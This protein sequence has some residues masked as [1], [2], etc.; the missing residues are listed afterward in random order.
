MTCNTTPAVTFNYAAWV[1]AYPQ[2][3]NV[4]EAQATF[5]FQIA[6][7]YCANCLRIV[8]CVDQ[9]QA[10][11]WMLTAHIAW[12]QCMR[13]ANGNPSSSGTIPPPAIVGRI[14]QATE[15]SVTVASEF[16]SQIPLQAAWFL[17]TPW[18]AMFWQAT[19]QYRTMRYFPGVR[20]GLTLGQIPWQY[21]NTP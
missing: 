19:A 3:Q 16:A 2:F 12:L 21:P 13:D 17:Q 5:F 20:R 4:N 1:A 6:T 8:Q 15:G 9:L 14:S 7:L 11:L 10:L 18:G